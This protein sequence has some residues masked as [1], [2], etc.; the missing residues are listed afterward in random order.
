MSV[1]MYVYIYIYIPGKPYEQFFSFIMGFTRN[2]RF[3]LIQ[4]R[5]L[6]FDYEG[7]FKSFDNTGSDILR[8]SPKK[9]KT[10]ASWESCPGTQIWPQILPYFPPNLDVPIKY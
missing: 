8:Q 7:L 2:G 10:G 6:V 4:L 5:I 9:N 1:Y 3:F